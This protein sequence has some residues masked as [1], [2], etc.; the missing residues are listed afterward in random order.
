MSLFAYCNKN[1]ILCLTALL[2]MNFTHPKKDCRY[3]I[4][5]LANESI[6]E[7]RCINYNFLNHNGIETHTKSTIC[8]LSSDNQHWVNI[9]TG[10]F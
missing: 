9:L 1:D 5:L 6:D 4:T 10:Y 7:K 3:D 2:Q 8:F